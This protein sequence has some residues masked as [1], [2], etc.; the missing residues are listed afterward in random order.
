[1]QKMVL[2]ENLH[3]TFKTACAYWCRSLCLY[4]VPSPFFGQTWSFSEL[5]RG[6]TVHLENQRAAFGS[7]LVLLR[8]LR[9]LCALP[10]LPLQP[11]TRGRRLGGEGTRSSTK[12]VPV[13]IA[14]PWQAAGAGFAAGRHMQGTLGVPRGRKPPATAAVRVRVLAGEGRCRENEVL[15]CGPPRPGGTPHCGDQV[16]SPLFFF[17][18]PL[19]LFSSPSLWFSQQKDSDRRLRRGSGLIAEPIQRSLHC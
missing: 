11:V 12:S 2:V 3:L 4:C 1:M 19:F 17:F 7:L 18:F 16:L 15:A 6:S 9:G 5:R 13:Q 8:W 10:L 14:R